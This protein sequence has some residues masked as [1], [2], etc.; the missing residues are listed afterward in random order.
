MNN[1]SLAGR[2]QESL[3]RLGVPAW[4]F[5]D[6]RFT[7]PLA[8]RIL[9]IH[10]SRHPTRRW[11]YLVPA[12]G[13]PIKLVHR[14]ESSMLDHLPGKKLVYLRWQDLESGLG[15]MLKEFSSVAMQYSPEGAIPYVSKVD[16]GTIELVRSLGKTVTSSADLVQSF[17]AVLTPGQLRE[18]HRASRAVSAIVLD[19][20]RFASS[21]IRRRGS[22]SEAEV[23][24]Y[25]LKRFQDRSL[26][27]D[28]GPIVAV[29]RHSG[30]P[31]Y[32]TASGRVT[33]IKAGDLLLIDLWA[34]T[35]TPGSVF[36]DITW[37]AFFGGM[38]EERMRRVFEVVRRGRDA[39][40]EF[41]QRRRA[42]GELP[43]G[44]EVDDAVRR[45]I[46]GLGYGEAFVHRTGHSL[47][48]EI[49]G[50]GVNFDNLETHDT[51]RLIPGVLCTIEPGV[52]L[53][54]FGI[55]SEI[56]VYMGEEGPEVTTPLQDAIVRPE[57]E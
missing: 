32:E 3:N 53:D 41:L 52:Y 31:H 12:Q 56:N 30:D 21:A 1:A 45:T 35:D 33:R 11:F 16:A 9:G 20:F 23:R 43:Q 19:A 26:V 36:A 5:Y 28:S 27:T 14:I 51:R 50:N 42:A 25:I 2:I 8:N 22:S 18:H 13:T 39:G 46:A 47:G 15:E 38:P 4:L 40:V 54:D 29:N 49:H 34:K 44:W 10:E 7:D 6:F 24:D 57:E 48:E 37:T 55:R 17:E